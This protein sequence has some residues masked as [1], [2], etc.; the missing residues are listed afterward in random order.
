ML[1]LIPLDVQSL[2]LFP[3]CPVANRFFY[4]FIHTGWLHMSVNIW[5]LLCIVFLYKIRPA[6]LLESYLISASFPCSLAGLIGY[7]MLPTVGLS[8]MIYALLGLYSTQVVNKIRYHGWWA[9][10]IGIG[11]FFRGSNALLH[12]YCYLVGFVWSLL[13]YYRYG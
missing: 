6:M 8:G 5:C 13:K 2:G 3:T 10:F 1:K 7:D 11:F 4:Q 9:V 12:L